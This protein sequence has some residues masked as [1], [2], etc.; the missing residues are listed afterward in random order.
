MKNK[1]KNNKDRLLYGAFGTEDL[2]S[3]LCNFS[4]PDKCWLFLSRFSPDA[5][6]KIME[7]VGLTG[8]LVKKGFGEKD[9]LLKI[10]I[11]ESMV[12]YLRLYYK[13]EDPDN[14]MIDLRMSEVKF[15]PKPWGK[16]KDTVVYDMIVT[17]WL[18][19]QDPLKNE[20]D[21]KKPRLPG[22]SR[23]GLGVL[24]YCFEMMYKVAR[25]V[26]KDG[27][28]DVPDHMHGAIMYSKKYMFYDPVHEAILKAILR[29]LGDYPLG[30][31]SWGMITGTIVEKNS[32]EPQE[33]S[34]SE[35]IFPV[36]DRMK[37]YF[38]SREYRDRFDSVYKKKK[39]IFDYDRMIKKR[40]EMLK[41]S[42]DISF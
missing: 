33:F 37:E 29:D 14:L 31:I 26:F 20:F 35:Q 19:T 38:Q 10:N 41:G 30:D 4:S 17:E 27:F 11:D 32:G 8:F 12:N 1:G 24:K 25:E 28:M 34:P 23:P 21:E 9:L 7:K 2:N 39:Y 16:K 13:K 5:L 36:S 40:E 6:L 42:K 3:V 22:Q 18:A 15:V